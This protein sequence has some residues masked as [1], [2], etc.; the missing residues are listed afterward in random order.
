MP[1][2][3]DLIF[4]AQD[5]PGNVH[6]VRGLLDDDAPTADQDLKH[7]SPYR[8]IVQVGMDD[9][10]L[11]FVGPH[12]YGTLDGALLITSDFFE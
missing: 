5:Q 12:K 3:W 7:G 1:I 11:R 8:Y 10:P 2:P 6:R 9:K 4:D